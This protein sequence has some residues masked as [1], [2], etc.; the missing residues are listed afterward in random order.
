MKKRPIKAL[1]FTLTVMLLAT[2]FA[3]AEDTPADVKDKSY[4]K[5]VSALIEKGIVVGDTDGS[6]HPDDTLTRAQACVIIV[7]SMNPPIV[8]VSATVTQPTPKS[9][10]SDMNGY[11]WA[12]GYI[13][14]AVQN[15]ITKGYP[16]G[17]FKPG[18]K[19]TMN[20]LVTMVLRAADYTDS[21]IGGVWPANYINKATELQ[22][23]Q[24]LPTPLPGLATKWMAAQLD[25]NA[26]DKIEAA[27]PAKATT[28][29][30]TYIA[31]LDSI[32]DVASMTYVSGK[33]N[34]TMTAFSGK[35]ISKDVKIYTYGLQKDYSGTMKFTD[36]LADYHGDTVYKYKETRT[37]AFYKVENGQIVAMILPTDVGFTNK[38]YCV[39]NS[40]VKTTNGSNEAVT[41]LVT[42]TAG[43]SITW[44]CDKTL[45]GIPA[46]EQ[47]LQGELYE[48]DVENGEVQGI[49]KAT[50]ENKKGIVF[51]EISSKRS[52]FVTVESCDSHAAKINEAG[53]NETV[54]LKDT[55]TVY[56]ID[57]KSNTGYQQV[58]VSEIKAGTQIRAYD[59]SDDLNLSADIII[60]KNS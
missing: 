38:V 15:N 34:E 9:G 2:T 52:G 8:E 27:N 21:S 59:I 7:K 48:L 20:E 46:K 41:G 19:V 17:T 36:K 60:I 10:F 55:M 25:Y 37:P 16:D 29:Q 22:L 32:P 5:A 13:S 54:V 3:Y 26:L 33:F 56:R 6:F 4:E 50:D 47:F 42:L 1:A 40:T 35:P 57:S 31:K 11:G 14:Y 39:I 18:S 30:D 24:D 12:E 53:G 28:I 51:K 43:R 44:L 23:L 45:S 49:C 58:S